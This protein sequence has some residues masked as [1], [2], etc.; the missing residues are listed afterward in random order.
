MN[1]TRRLR[2]RRRRD[3]RDPPPPPGH[4]RGG[5]ASPRRRR[6]A[7]LVGGLVSALAFSG[8]AAAG[9]LIT[10]RDV[11]DDTV[12]SVD[13]RDGRLQGVDVRDGSLTATDFSALP[14]GDPGPQGGPGSRG[15]D[16]VGAVIRPNL[17]RIVQP[18]AD[19]DFTTPCPNGTHVVGGGVVGGLSGA[20]VIEASHPAS[21]GWNVRARNIDSGFAIT[22]IG[23]AVCAQ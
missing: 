22:V 21:T 9:T 13:L 5:S 19:V 7:V 2:P 23:T 15:P 6:L 16:G 10:G 3:D 12:T 17:T 14:S 4:G 1:R 11:K 8:S 18:G 20:L